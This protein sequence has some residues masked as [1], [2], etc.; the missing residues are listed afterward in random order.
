MTKNKQK[1]DPVA[2][3]ADALDQGFQA[4]EQLTGKLMKAVK[5][6]NDKFVCTSSNVTAKEAIGQDAEV[7]VAIPPGGVGE[8]ILS[9]GGS[10]QH[11]SARGRDGRK[12]FKRGEKVRI[13]D[14][15]SGTLYVTEAR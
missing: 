7:I 9:L 3:A 5:Q 12:S 14:A 11:Y 10:L 6:V 1:V 13:M 2:V 8:V 15:A 4:A